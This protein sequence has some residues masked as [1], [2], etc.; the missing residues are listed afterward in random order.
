MGVFTEEPNDVYT[1]PN[2]NATFPC[3]NDIDVTD[4]FPHWSISGQIY[5]RHDI[6]SSGKYDYMNK[7]LTVLNTSLEDD[8]LTF[9]CVYR[10]NGED[11][12]SQT[13]TLRVLSG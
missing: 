4:D 6:L 1:T 5:S 9:K 8:G 12:E 13:A 10:V 3:V 11:I 7:K 2:Q